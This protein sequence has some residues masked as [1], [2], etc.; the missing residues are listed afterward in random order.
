MH[1]PSILA[2]LVLLLL[3]VTAA[4]AQTGK[5]LT[6]DVY[7]TWNRITGESLANNGAWLSYVLEPQEGDS[8]LILV[9]LSDGSADTIAR[10]TGA[11]ITEDS[12]FAVFTIKA[13]FAHVRKAKIAKKKPDDM[14]KDST[15]ILRLGTPGVT[16]IPRTRAFKLPE[17]GA[18]WA[19]ILLEKDLSLGDT[20]RKTTKTDALDEGTDDKDKKEE[21][22]TTLVL[23]ELETGTE[24]RF[25]YTSDY[26]FSRKGNRLLVVTTGNDSTVP[27]GVFVYDTDRRAIDTLAIGKGKYRQ[28]AWDEDGS[29]AAFIADRDTSKSKQRYP[30]LL[31]WK[32]GSDSAEILADTSTTGF[33]KGWLISDA[34]T[35]RF[36]RDGRRLFFGTAPVPMPEDTTLNDEITARLDVWNWQDGFLQTHQLKDLES[37]RKRSY[38]GLVQLTD[39]RYVQLADTSLPS[40]TTGDEGNADIALGL[41][42]LPYR[43]SVSWEG[44]DFNDVYLVNVASGS[45]TRVLERFSGPVSLSPGARYIT[46]Y[47]TKERHWY[48]MDVRSRKAVK[49]TAPIRFPLY[50]ELNDVPKDPDSYGIAGWMQNDSVLFVYDRYD[51]WG[52][53]PAGVRPSFCL[54]RNVG[55]ADTI[56]FRS[57]RFDPEERFWKPDSF[58]YLQAFNEK[59]KS[60]GYY[61]VKLDGASAPERLLMNNYAFST[62]RKAKNA[63]LVVLTK[64][65]F[66]T[67]PDLSVSYLHFRSL[68]PFSNANPQQKEY[69]WGSVELITWTAADGKPIDGLLY[70]P[71]DFDGA[72]KYPMI[73]Y[74]YER[75][76]D[77]L[78]R[79]VSPAPSRS[80]INYSYCVS[81]GYVVFVPDIRYRVGHPGRSAFDCIVPGVR[82]IL[83]R[84][85]V[86]SSRIALQGQSWGGYQTAFLITQTP[87]FRCAFAGAPVSNMTSAYGGIRWESGRVREFQ[88]EKE[89]SRIGGTLWEKRD[90]YLENS[91]LFHVNR[92]TTPLLIMANDNDGAVPWQ[93][94]IELFTALRRLNKPAWML[95]YNN[96]AHNLTQRKNMKDLNIRMMQFFDHYLKSAP[97]PVWM[98]RGIPAVNKGKTLGY[99]TGPLQ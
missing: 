69:R 74:Y 20:T 25:P 88:Y 46:W 64:S 58:L 99:E 61:R 81:N 66:T 15:G 91:P 5:S 13:P 23:R 65:N 30:K 3:P 16:I 27:P 18:G 41:S 52:V 1:C 6:H 87:M 10:A 51:I 44:D 40:L 28:P 86:D 31:Y 85:F 32:A 98:S 82:E 17:K 54:T 55:R 78:H 47:V 73:V 77:L 24:V 29:Q 76:S 2:P 49:V 90:L 7:D 83:R 38:T 4:D 79:Y 36:S 97:M 93:Q 42:D 14:P 19:A 48:A 68:R 96:E 35:P 63:D 39:R 22:G 21:K 34:A 70:K 33:R 84:G 67:F 12:R 80:T 94:G 26:L 56:R 11:Q 9:R 57:I 89:Q 71:G 8:R 50:N 59:N 95:V 53:D 62:P 75:N 72:K 60:S 92:V 45:R 43:R 37:E